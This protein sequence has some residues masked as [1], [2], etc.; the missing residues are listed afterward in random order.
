MTASAE[1]CIKEFQLHFPINDN[2]GWVGSVVEVVKL[3]HCIKTM[4]QTVA[5]KSEAIFSS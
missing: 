1:Y 5:I 3:K 2:M 4:R